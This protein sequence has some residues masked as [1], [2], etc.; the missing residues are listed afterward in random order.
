MDPTGNQ[1]S[2]AKVEWRVDIGRQFATFVSG[3]YFQFFKLL[4]KIGGGL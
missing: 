4:R 1:A 2:I 3:M